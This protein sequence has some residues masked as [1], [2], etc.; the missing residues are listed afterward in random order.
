MRKYAQ[1]FHGEVIYIIDSFASLSDLREHFS[2]DTLWLDVTDVE[3]I[4]VGYIQFVDRD[5]RITF[6]PGVDNEFESLSESEKINVM[7]YA[8]KVK[9]DEYLD[10]LAQSKRY[11]DARDCFDYDYG[12][13]SDGHKLKDLKFKL[14]QFILDRVPSLISL[15]AARN[16]DFKSEAKRLEFE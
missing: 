1:I 3:D 9:R 16:L 13:Y 5:G 14:D 10:E 15:D 11:L 8:A 4:E 6:R 12:I 7:I 2:E